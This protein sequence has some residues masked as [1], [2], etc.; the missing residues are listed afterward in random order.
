MTGAEWMKTRF[1]SGKA[2]DIARL[3]YT[4]FAI[5]TIT[6]LLGYG[7]IGMGKFGSIFLPFSPTTCAFLILGIT[8]A[9]VVLGGFHGIVRV[10]IL[11]TAVLSA[12]AI[13]FAVIGFSHFNAAEFASKVPADWGNIWPTWRPADFQGLISGGTDYSLF[14]ALVAVWVAK[15]LMLCL[16]GPEQLYDFQRFLAA[17]DERDASKLGAL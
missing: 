7:A 1:G 14:G 5:L 17:K 3:S 6:A 10:E 2:G 16:S 8:G 12:G 15:G 4:I 9:Y 13:A 11:Q